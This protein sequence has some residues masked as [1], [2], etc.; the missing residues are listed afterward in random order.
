MSLRF[1]RPNRVMAGWLVALAYLVCIVSPGAALA[2]G[3]GPAPCLTDEVFALAFAP[4]DSAAMM[5]M[6]ADGP[7]HDHG[8][9]HVHH[10]HHAGAADEPAGHHGKGSALPG[11]CC[12]MMCVS[13]IPADLPAIS[14]PSQPFSI[15]AM[16]TIQSAPGKA[17]PLLY[18]PP[19]A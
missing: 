3:S 8:G 15:C 16:E 14:A 4:D 10:H 11:P 1:A 6:T 7:T 2:F 5:S 19:I 18:R 17:P 9:P 12:A 13:A